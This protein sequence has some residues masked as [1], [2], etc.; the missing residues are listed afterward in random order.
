MEQHTQQK[1]FGGIVQFLVP[2]N[3]R[4][5]NRV[6]RRR[7]RGRQVGQWLVCTRKVLKVEVVL[8]QVT[9]R[10]RDLDVGRRHRVG[11]CMSEC[12]LCADCKWHE[13]MPP[14]PLDEVFTTEKKKTMTQ[15]YGGYRCETPMSSRVGI[16]ILYEAGGVEGSHGLFVSGGRKERRKGWLCVPF[17]NSLSFS[18][19]SEWEKRGLIHRQWSTLLAVKKGWLSARQYV[20]TTQT[21]AL[22]VLAVNQCGGWRA[23]ER[24][25][26]QQVRIR[27]WV[28]F[29]RN[30][31]RSDDGLLKAGGCR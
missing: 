20:G 2:K 7:W 10:P 16:Y 5:G 30:G 11:V 9:R 27:A 25:A 24:R 1:C 3:R 15:N 12:V 21:S 26:P 6:A 4:G 13:I 29:W 23:E 17:L 18:L 28:L 8:V 19:S 14:K 22:R 31:S